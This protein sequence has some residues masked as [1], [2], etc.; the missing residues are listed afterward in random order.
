MSCRV[1][2]AVRAEE[3]RPGLPDAAV[4][5]TLLEERDVQRACQA[6][7]LA[8][9]TVAWAQWQNQHETV[10][11]ARDGDIVKYRSVR[12]KL[13]LMGADA[14]PCAA[15]FVNTARTGPVAVDFPAGGGTAGEFVDFRGRAIGA[16]GMGGPDRGRG[17]R[18]L[19]LGPG[20][21][22]PEGIGW[23]FLVRSPTF[24]LALTFR[25]ARPTRPSGSG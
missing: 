11:G 3:E 13:G 1:F 8:L 25:I 12:D 14:A 15:G 6:W 22:P 16:V 17:G 20:Q 21:A 19:V 4:I 2:H 23:D 9:P 7:L 18:Y 10:F 24:N 5:A